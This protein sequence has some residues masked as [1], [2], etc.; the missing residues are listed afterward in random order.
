[1]GR[2]SG[3]WPL[4]SGG[5]PFGEGF[6]EYYL[7]LSKGIFHLRSSCRG[8]RFPIKA[9][10]SDYYAVLLRSQCVLCPNG[11]YTWSYRFFEAA[12]CGAIPI[13]EE[14][15]PVYR[16]FR[17]YRMSDNHYDWDPAAALHNYQLCAERI[18]VP[19]DL[20][21]HAIEEL[22]AL[23]QQSLTASLCFRQTLTGGGQQ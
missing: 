3:H 14:D 9:W 16:G 19:A 12:L 4:A 20:I 10:D 1:M 13:I 23:P 5:N 6:E 17:Y 21:H 15:C 18:L 11:E 8:R 22:V 2:Q 7:P